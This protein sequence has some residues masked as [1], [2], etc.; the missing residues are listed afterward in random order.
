MRAG[1]LQCSGLSSAELGPGACAPQ[2]RRAGFVAPWPVGSSWASDRACAPCM[3]GPGSPPAGARGSLVF[4][5]H[6]VLLFYS[7]H[8]VILVALKSDCLSHLRGLRLE[9]V[10]ESGSWQAAGACIF[11]G[12]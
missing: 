10:D 1:F 4:V 12:D 11:S 9:R 7:P 6:S 5:F 3:G 8:L 2:L